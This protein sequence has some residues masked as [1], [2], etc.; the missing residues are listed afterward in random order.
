MYGLCMPDYTR[1][2]VNL[3]PRSVAAMN[4]ASEINGDNRTDSINRA[5]Q[6][7]AYL[8]QEMQT[9]DVVVRDRSGQE[10]LLRMF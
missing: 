8:M 1:V 4:A 9:K 5:L 10:T 6:V 3:V 7:Y 2:T